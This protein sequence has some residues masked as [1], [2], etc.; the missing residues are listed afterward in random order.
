M[1]EISR[2]KPVVKT[3]VAPEIEEAVVEL[4]CRIQLRQICELRCFESASVRLRESALAQLVGDP[5]LAEGASDLAN[6]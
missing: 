5:H 2:R 1:Q 3:C 4:R 6:G